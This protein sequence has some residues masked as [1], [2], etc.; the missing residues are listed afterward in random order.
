MKGLGDL[1]LGRAG[2]WGDAPAG[3]E[4]NDRNLALARVFR[5]NRGPACDYE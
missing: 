4:G 1:G 5:S 3:R 2:A